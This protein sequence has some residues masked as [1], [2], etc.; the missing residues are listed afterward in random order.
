MDPRTR[1]HMRPRTR[2]HRPLAAFAALAVA[3]LLAAALAPVVRAEMSQEELEATLTRM[4]DDVDAAVQAYADGDRDTALEKARAVASQFSFGDEDDQGASPLEQKIKE[5]SAIAIGDQVK[6]W[7]G[8]LVSAI[9]AGEDVA[10]IQEI[11]DELA[12]SLN[13]L[14]LVAQGKASP[15]SQR[16]LRTPD[17][18]DAAAQAVRDL[19]DEAVRLYEDGQTAKAKQTAEEAFFTYETNPAVGNL[20]PDVSTVDDDLENEVENLIQQ[21]QEG[22]EPGLSQLIDQG[23]PLDEVRAQRDRIFTGLDEIVE[24]LKATLPPL[25]LG[26]ANGDGTVSI[27]DALLVAQASLGVRERTDGMDVN[28]DGRVS[29]VDALLVAQAALG[30]RTL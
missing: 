30:V 28:R 11:A 12:P 8:R 17:E 6:A 23:A 27:V 19:V 3:L 18:I 16:T 1:T 9:E 25:S 21:F 26:D 5:I 2:P 24:L 29:I 20:G 4:Q 10:R 14:V 13:R 15:A 7:S 22:G